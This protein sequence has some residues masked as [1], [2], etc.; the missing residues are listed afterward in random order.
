VH[1]W[2][3][4]DTA[5]FYMLEDGSV[6]RGVTNGTAIPGTTGLLERVSFDGTTTWQMQVSNAQR[7]MHH[8][9]HY[10]PNGNVLVLAV[11]LL[12][13]ADAIAAGRDPATIIGPWMPDS[14]LEIQP[15]GPTSGVVVWEWHTMDHIVQDRDP[16][17]PKFGVVSDHP[18]LLDINFP[19]NVLNGDA[20]NHA[21]GLDYHADNDWIVVSFRHQNEIY[22]I[23]HSTTTAEAAGH[24]G[25]ARGKG[26]DFLWRWGNPQAYKRGTAADQRLGLQHDPRWIPAGYPGA[27]HVPV[28]NN[29]HAPGRS[30]VIDLDMPLDGTGNPFL[31]PFTGRFGPETLVW[32]FQEPG[33]FSAFVSSA[34]RLKSGNTLICSGQQ[35]WLFE[36]TPKGKTVWSYDVPGSPF[37]FQAHAVENN[38]FAEAAEL[39]AAAGGQIQLHHLLD[40]SRAGENYLL[41][42]SL[43]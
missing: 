28:F 16:L 21:N 35:S 14:I 1:S 34:Q 17:L 20:F 23:D 39:P 38:L 11:E 12:T 10:M 15:T 41:L 32:E 7:A 26:G 30:A 6:I 24:T 42:G 13:P 2:P 31:D 3:G 19:G 5:T 22:L 33:F 25:G 8:D 40:S 27:G 43:T 4:A 37:L 29:A 36:V 9:I 18:E